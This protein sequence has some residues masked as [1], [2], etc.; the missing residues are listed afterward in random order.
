MCRAHLRAAPRG[1]G[2][3]GEGGKGAGHVSTTSC[4]RWVAAAPGGVSDIPAH[5]TQRLS[6]L[7]QPNRAL[8]QQRLVLQAGSHCPRNGP[9]GPQVAP[10][11]D[12]GDVGGIPTASATASLSCILL[13]PTRCGAHARD[14]ENTWHI[15]LNIYPP[16]KIE[17]HFHLSLTLSITAPQYPELQ[18]NSNN[19]IAEKASDPVW[20]AIIMY[21]VP[22]TPD[23][24]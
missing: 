6:I 8:R 21:Q 12:G 22:Y 5:S 24:I 4:L 3:G 23:L 17:R 15:Q 18:N 2:R 13:C 9:H 7:L 1:G 14:P 19:N 20:V 11:A 10:G 16:D